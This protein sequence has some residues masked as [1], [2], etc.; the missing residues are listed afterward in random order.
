MNAGRGY[1]NG[2]E[3]SL[4]G[5]GTDFLGQLETDASGS[6]TG[7]QIIEAGKNYSSYQSIEIFDEN[8][9]DGTIRPVMGSLSWDEAE[10][11][12]CD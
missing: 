7:V 1:T 12:A 8:G 10:V 11:G 9:T 3:V 2:S 5:S 4:V 6:I